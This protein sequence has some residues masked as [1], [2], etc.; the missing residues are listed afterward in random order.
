MEILCL[1]GA[2]FLGIT[3]IVQSFRAYDAGQAAEVSERQREYAERRLI[4]L[5][6]EM[7]SLEKKYYK[8]V[9]KI[10]DFSDSLES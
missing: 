3:A 10:T 5:R 4:D 8:M 2:L 1:I 6:D 7:R 9:Q